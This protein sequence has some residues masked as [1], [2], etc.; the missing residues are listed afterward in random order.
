MVDYIYIINIFI[1]YILFLIYVTYFGIEFSSILTFGGSA[2][3]GKGIF[4]E[5]NFTHS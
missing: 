4:D 2:F 5:R 1:F 3:F